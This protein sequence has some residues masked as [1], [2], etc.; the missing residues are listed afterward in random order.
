MTSSLNDFEYHL[1]TE[2]YQIHIP[3]PLF[4]N[5]RLTYPAFYLYISTCL[6]KDIH[7]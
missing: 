1:Y 7:T 3:C 4:L 6:L 2:D 5:S